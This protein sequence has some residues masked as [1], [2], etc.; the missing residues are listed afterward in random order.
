MVNV[1]WWVKA[2]VALSCMLLGVSFGLAGNDKALQAVLNFYHTAHWLNIEMARL[3]TL[4]VFALLA[5]FSVAQSRWLKAELV[6]A[7]MIGLALVALM[8]L[9]SPTRWIADLGGFP[10]IGSGQGIIKY[11]ALIPLAFYLFMKNK[12]SSFFHALFN[13][14]SIVLVLVWIGGMKFTTIEAKG[15]EALVA[16]SPFLSWLYLFFDVQRASDLIGVYDLVC[17]ALL[18]I[19]LIFQRPLVAAT[20]LV[21]ATCVFIVTQSFLFTFSGA[22][23]STSVLSS[24]GQF[25]I[26]DLWFTAN[27]VIVGAYLWR[28]QAN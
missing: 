8:T 19:G 17:A 22:L 5:L 11:Y 2:L 7:L 3:V 27:A 15:I 6:A 18:L 25:L 13:A 1:Y 16:T 20:G 23:S 12:F 21:G 9:L 26:K 10:A 4:S 28:Q 24:T 14:T